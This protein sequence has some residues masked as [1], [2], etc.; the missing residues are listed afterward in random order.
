M[1]R[2]LVEFTDGTSVEY[3]A[4]GSDT[5]KIRET[6]KKKLE[7]SHNKQVASLKK[8]KIKDKVKKEK[9]DKTKTN[10]KKS[11]IGLIKQT[12]KGSKSKNN[13]VDNNSVSVAGKLNSIENS[14]E[15]LFSELQELKAS[16]ILSRRRQLIGEL[17]LLESQIL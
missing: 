9:K 3:G 2:Y 16:M 14:L 7:N 13:S 11:S 8:V 17:E 4:P 6:V 15:T 12:G 5:E 10:S 1:P